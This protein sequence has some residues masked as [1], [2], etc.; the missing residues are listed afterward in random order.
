[1]LNSCIQELAFTAMVM[2]N[3]A[4]NR[5]LGTPAKVAIVNIVLVASAFI[6]YF[7][8]FGFI[9]NAITV[10]AFS[11][12]ETLLIWGLNILGIAF[13][14]IFGAILIY[15]W[16]RRVP[17][18][19]YWTLAGA[20][21]SLLPFVANIE[22]LVGILIFST[23]SGIYFGLGIP[24][25]MGYFSSSTEAGNRARLGGLTF[26]T[27]F[28]G[29]FLIR[30]LNINSTILNVAVLSIV[31]ATGFAILF[32]LKPA[33]KHITQSNQESYLEVFKNRSFLLYFIPWCMFSLVNYLAVP[34]TDKIFSASF[35]Q[36]SS[37][38]ENVLSAVFAV[39][40]GFYADSVGRKR[41]LVAGFALLGLG[42]ASLGLF[43]GNSYSSWFYISVD[44]L[45]WG[46][47]YTLFI[48]TLWGDLAPQG[49]GSEKYYAIG[50]LPFLFSVFMQLFVGSYFAKV[51]S[52]STIFSF[53]SLF[54][55]LAVLPLVYAP[56]TL[57]EKVMKEKALKNYAELAQKIKQKHI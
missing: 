55:F 39:V 4:F 14:A 16:N 8:V 40:V 34:V 9:D 18:L 28:V 49:K 44:G 42:Y 51:V 35:Y 31:K 47:F 12:N 33:E 57:S 37:V 22:N 11:N 2:R 25:C 52:N 30:T 10:G 48:T 17:F 5:K 24:S 1:M 20:I 21:L 54:L 29:F 46:A 41:L 32:V 23:T 19:L 43:P 13:S 6:W 27:I 50:S 15:K 7:L 56:E 53:A 36:N 26:L 38:I 45:A 3:E